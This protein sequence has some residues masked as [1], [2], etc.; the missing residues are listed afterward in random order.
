MSRYFQKITLNELAEKL[1]PIMQDE[2]FPYNLPK[3][4]EKDLK[5]NFDWENYEYGVVYPANEPALPSTNAKGFMNYPCGF[6]VLPNGMPALF[7][8]A[9]GDWETPVCFA[10]YWDGSALRGYVPTNGNMFNRKTKWAFGNEG[11]SEEQSNEDSYKMIK[12]ML[13]EATWLD[14][15]TLK[16]YEEELQREFEDDNAIYAINS[17]DLSNKDA[18]YKD[19]MER[20]VEK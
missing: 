16:G 3:S 6:Q 13:Q 12:A 9:G 17:I 7:I 8:N 20:I 15:E 4:V 1:K 10:I 14:A 5:V 19:I 2:D 11:E 18:I